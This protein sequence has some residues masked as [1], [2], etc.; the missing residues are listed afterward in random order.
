MREN[1]HRVRLGIVGADYPDGVKTAEVTI[2]ANRAMATGR[3]VTL[4]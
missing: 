4:G 1:K 3:P 2:A